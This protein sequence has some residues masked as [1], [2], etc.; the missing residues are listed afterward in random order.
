MVS[1]VS[2]QSLLEQGEPKKVF[3][4]AY[5]RGGST[6]LG[7]VFNH[8]PEVIVWYEPLASFYGSLYGLPKYR[9]YRRVVFPGDGNFKT[10]FR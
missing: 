10:E 7:Q 9:H 6:L 3:I 1:C 4:F 2:L 8:D 5:M